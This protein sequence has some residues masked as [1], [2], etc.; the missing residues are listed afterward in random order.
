[1]SFNGP[2]QSLT[3]GNDVRATLPE[4]NR[5]YL[6]ESFNGWLRALYPE[7]IN[8]DGEQR[9]YV[10]V[11][12]SDDQCQPFPGGLAQM[13]N[14]ELIQLTTRPSALGHEQCGH[15]DIGDPVADSRVR[16]LDVELLGS[17][18]GDTP[19]DVAHMPRCIRTT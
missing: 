18:R 4:P 16:V 15:L 6:V 2:L 7:I 12:S 3:L 10:L 14:P 19:R 17:R 5:G 1:M 13:P 9:Q 8:W 11:N